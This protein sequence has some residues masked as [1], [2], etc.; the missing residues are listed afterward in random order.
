[1]LSRIAFEGNVIRAELFDR[2]TAEETRTFLESVL[3]AAEAHA[4][5]RV[6]IRVSASKPLFK[7]DQ[8]GIGE[9]LRLLGENR[10]YRVALL[11][12]TEETHMSHQYV[13][14]LARQHHAAV[15]SFRN[16]QAALEWLRRG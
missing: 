9:Y 2:K 3:R 16:E 4:C 10:S 6:L 15:R 12:D 7:V 11:S 14:L 1:M 13:E 8:Y 5:T